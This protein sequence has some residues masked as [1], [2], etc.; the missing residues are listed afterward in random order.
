MG[1]TCTSAP[2]CRRIPGL[3]LGQIANIN[4]TGSENVFHLQVAHASYHTSSLTP[5]CWFR[6]S[7]SALVVR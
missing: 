4:L 5:A 2:S 7:T 3:T 1:S 6:D